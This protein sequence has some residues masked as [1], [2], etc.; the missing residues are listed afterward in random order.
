MPDRL[1]LIVILMVGCIA[2]VVCVD[3]PLALSIII[4]ITAVCLVPFVHRPPSRGFDLFEPVYITVISMWLAYGMN[5][6]AIL[7]FPDMVASLPGVD[8]FSKDLTLVLSI[9]LLGIFF[10]II[11]YSLPFPG[12]LV[13]QGCDFTLF[14]G[15]EGWWAKILVLYCFGWGVRILFLFQGKYTAFIAPEESQTSN[16][17][18][19]L[20]NLWLIPIYAYVLAWIHWANPKAPRFKAVQ[21]IA[22][23]TILEVGFFLFQ[24]SKTYLTLLLLLPLVALHYQGI[25]IRWRILA[26]AALTIALVV[27]PYVGAYRDTILAQSLGG[28]AD[29]I[30]PA[31]L[32]NSATEAAATMY[33]RSVDRSGN[34]YDA[35][36]SR[37]GGV[38]PTVAIVERVPNDFPYLYGEDFALLPFVLVP[39]VV[40]PWKP[41]ARSNS[42]LT[43][44]IIGTYGCS[45]SPFPIG[46]WYL[47]FGVVGVVLGMLFFGA[48]QRGYYEMLMGHPDSLKQF[49]YVGT[50]LPI[51]NINSWISTTVVVG[52]IQVVAVLLI[53]VYFMGGRL[54]RGT[55]K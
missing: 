16:A 1:K 6:L 5:G 52:L 32:Y 4:G 46:E 11:G 35:F 9:I 36:F 39:R 51:T 30:S 42:Y 33:D 15:I 50:F 21:L 44:D 7:Y 19:I 55:V 10:Y 48:F 28:D 25:R 26:I 43:E 27:F 3:E 22:V 14:R 53:I 49:I 24:G 29:L 12:R 47:N 37:W 23:L 13:T 8:V 20:Y 38:A 41:T 34:V 18:A 2:A 40:I 54:R 45:I 17:D 31:V